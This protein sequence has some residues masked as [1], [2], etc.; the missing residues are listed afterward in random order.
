M[1]FKENSFLFK[2]Q[3]SAYFF[4]AYAINFIFT[5]TSLYLISIPYPVLWFFQIFSPTISAV[6]ISGLIGGLVEIKKLFSG[7]SRWKVGLIWYMAAF[8]LTLFP[9]LV[10]FIYA[11]LGNPIPGIAPGTPIMFLLSNLV[12]TLFSGPLAEEAGWRG[13]ALPRL[14]KRFNALLSS[15]ILGVIWACWH[16]PFYARSGGGAGMQFIIYFGMVMVLTIFIT[17]IYN[18]TNGSLGLCVITHFCFNFDSAF[19]AGYLGLLPRMVFN[20]W[21]GALLGVYII[22]IIFVFGPKY[23][24]KKQT[25]TGK[26]ISA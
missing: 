1:Y 6:V 22:V 23:L 24:S 11:V 8:S 9:L 7:F 21:C 5:F 16:L 3:L 20:I 2:H 12:F 19:I 17:W 18:N 14:Q 10:S 13:F 4:L 26:V 15:I 25:S